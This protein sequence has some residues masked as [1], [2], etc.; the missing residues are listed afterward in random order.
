MNPAFFAP[1]PSLPWFFFISLRQT[2][3]PIIMKRRIKAEA[4]I[5]MAQAGTK[6]ITILIIMV[7]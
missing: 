6:T 2:Q 4:I 7:M 1:L 5:N 3:I